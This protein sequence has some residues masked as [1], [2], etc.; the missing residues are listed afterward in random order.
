MPFA[1]A[2]VGAGVSAAAGLAG[3]ALQAGATSSAAN[4][5]NATQ[6]MAYRIAEAKLAPYTSAGEGALGDVSGILGLQGPDVQRQAYENFTA[7]PGYQFAFDQ[8]LRAVDAGAASRGML[9]SGATLKAEEQ[10]GQGL[11]AQQFGDYVNRLYSL[12]TLGQKSTLQQAD[13]TQTTGANLARTDIGVGN[14]MSSIYGNAAQGI[15]GTA[16]ALLN[17][18][19]VQN[20]LGGSNYGNSA[21]GTPGISA[22][23]N[24]VMTGY[25]PAMTP[26]QVG[27]G[28]FVAPLAPAGF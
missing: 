9:R 18:P 19:S 14:A 24:P 23:G 12:A 8:G 6:E 11:A 17:N 15:G 1:V 16:N 5:A 22:A 7:Y 3:S 10:F 26:G 28:G 20:W 13:Q 27:V 4:K 2:A 25:A 21:F